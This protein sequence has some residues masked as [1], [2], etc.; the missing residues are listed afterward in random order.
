MPQTK[1]QRSTAAKKGAA[2]RKRNKT[3]ADSEG[4]GRRL[5]R[6]AHSG[7]SVAEDAKDLAKTAGSAAKTTAEA[8]AQ[9]AREELRRRSH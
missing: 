7:E 4:L 2:T 1:A 6:L 3:K 8:T 5:G 9:R